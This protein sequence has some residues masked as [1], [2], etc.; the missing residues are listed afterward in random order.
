MLCNIFHTA[1]KNVSNEI[2]D[3]KR[4]VTYLWK[5]KQQPVI[6]VMAEND[7]QNKQIYKICNGPYK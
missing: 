4:D 6:S 2:L 3:T 1:S 5:E 7:L